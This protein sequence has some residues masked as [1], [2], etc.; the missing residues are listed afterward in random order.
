MKRLAYNTTLVDTL[1]SQRIIPKVSLT[2]S[3]RTLV[4]FFLISFALTWGIAL[5]LILFPEPITSL[6]G[7][8]EMTNPL[9]ILAVYSPA[10]ASFG[11][12]LKHHGIKGV[13]AFLTRLSRWRAPVAWWVFLVIGIGALMYAGTLLKGTIG[14]D[15]FPFSPWYTMFSA[16]A[17]ALFIG[18]IEEFGWRGLALPF[19]QVR[20]SP[21]VSALILGV[22]WGIWHVPAFLL[23]GTPQSAWSFAPY[24]IAVVSISV[25]MTA[26]FNA[27]RGSL[28]LM[29][30]FHFQANNPIYPDAHPYDTITFTLAAIVVVILNRKTMFE[31]NAGWTEVIPLNKTDHEETS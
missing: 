2:M 25:I 30:L 28:L 4:H 13:L 21:I 16:L 6:F 5:L 8:I 22:I 31:R 23:G 26:L 10:F 3:S 12:I 11:L 24:F 19:L 18:P 20:Y 15:P 17:I 9:F 1:H 27:S 29:V 7:E 14:Q